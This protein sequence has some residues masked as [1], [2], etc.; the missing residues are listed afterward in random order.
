MESEEA[1][2]IIGYPAQNLE[3]VNGKVRRLPSDPYENYCREMSR[4]CKEKLF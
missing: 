4:E 1:L 3:M 2:K